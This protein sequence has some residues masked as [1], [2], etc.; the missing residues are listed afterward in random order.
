MIKRYHND[1]IY[2]FSRFPVASLTFVEYLPDVI[3]ESF[4]I[5]VTSFA[6]SFAIAKI[7]A[8]KHNYVVDP[9]QAGV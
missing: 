2:V 1:V 4:A 8:D 5:C 9:N 7:L 3:G 6:I